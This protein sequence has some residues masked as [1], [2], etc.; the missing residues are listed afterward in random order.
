MQT[1]AGS[2]DAAVEDVGR[3]LVA[4]GYS[5]PGELAVICMAVPFGSGSPPTR[6]TSTRSNS[7]ACCRIDVY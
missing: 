4:R 2:F 1:P 7:Q 6:C 5:K 3:E